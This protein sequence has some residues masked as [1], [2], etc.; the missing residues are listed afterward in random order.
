VRGRIDDLSSFITRT[1]LSVQELARLQSEHAQLLER[2]ARFEQLEWSAAEINEENIRLREQLGFSQT[3][4]FRHIPAR[5]IGRDPDNL[6]NAFVINQGRQAGVRRDMAVIAFQ[7]GSQ[8]LVGKVI[9]ARRFESLVMPLFDQN[10]LA[11][12]RFAFSRYEGIVEGQG[13]RDFPL[14][15]RFIPRHARE[16]ISIGDLVISS[17]LGGVYPAGINIGRVTHIIFHEHETSMEVELVPIIDFSRLEH[18]FV[19]EPIPYEY[20]TDEEL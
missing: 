2:F 15:M 17:G 5:I 11:A 20:E 4:N 19:I 12:S 3:L 13:S 1:I 18:V 7:G 10:L 14:R 6:F 8:A 16:E 9:E